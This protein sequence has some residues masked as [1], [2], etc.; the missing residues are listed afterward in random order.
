MDLTA[1]SHKA[2]GQDLEARPT[3]AVCVRAGTFFKSNLER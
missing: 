1:A 3:V 2:V